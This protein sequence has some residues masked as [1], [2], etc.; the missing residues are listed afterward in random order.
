MIYKIGT[1]ESKRYDALKALMCL[2][3]LFI[4]GFSQQYAGKVSGTKWWLYQIT[5]TVSRILCDCAVPV[6][7]LISSVMLFSKPFRW[8]QNVKK[9]FRSLVIPYLIFN[10]LWIVVVLCG[11]FLSRKLGVGALD[12]V[13]FDTRSPMGWVNAYLGFGGKPALTV[14]WY[15]RDLIIL[16]LLAVPIKKLVDWLPIPMLILTIVMW[17]VGVPIPVLGGYSLVAFIAGYYLVKYGLHLEDLD[18]KLKPCLMTAVFG[19]LLLADILLK[20]KN[21]YVHNGFILLAVVFYLRFSSKLLRF[22]KPVKIIAPAGFFIYLTHLF[23]YVVLKALIGDSFY[24]YFGTYFLLPAVA[25]GVLLSVFYLLRRF[26]PGL[27]TVLVGGRKPTAAGR[28]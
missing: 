14:L 24:V 21:I 4:H 22:E 19:A 25:L 6:F 10:S 16:N 5:F 27:L 2:F 26:L 15:V 13:N 11:R 7:M 12:I 28:R 1:E 18:R 23:V 20:R 17:F 8:W 3:V 9:K